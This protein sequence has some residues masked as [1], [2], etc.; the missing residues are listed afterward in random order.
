M[1]AGVLQSVYGSTI[2]IS[3]FMNSRL[4]NQLYIYIQDI[5]DTLIHMFYV[6]FYTELLQYGNTREDVCQNV[7][8]VK[9]AYCSIPPCFDHYIDILHLAL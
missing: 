5:K 2:D 6:A 8:L 9:C 7:A 1:A 3:V 4:T